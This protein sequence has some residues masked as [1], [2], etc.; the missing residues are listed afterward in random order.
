MSALFFH[1]LLKP[2]F[3]VASSATEN[4]RVV[5]AMLEALQCRNSILLDC[6]TWV[7]KKQFW[8]EN[9]RFCPG[10]IP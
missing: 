4:M 5:Y 3:M 7:G 8:R 10:L 6:I 1:V 9:Q 2:F